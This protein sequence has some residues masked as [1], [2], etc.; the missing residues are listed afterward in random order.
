RLHQIDHFGALGRWWF[1]QRDLLAGDF[2]VDRRLNARLHLVAVSTWIEG[3]A[4]AL[5]DQFARQLQFAVAHL[6]LRDVELLDR[7]DLIGVE[8]LLHDQS[9]LDRPQHHDVLLAARG[10]APDRA[11]P[12]LT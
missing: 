4:S 11:Q 1:G 6:R 5:F 2:L 8:Q 10:P 3:V 12:R 9:I 7:A